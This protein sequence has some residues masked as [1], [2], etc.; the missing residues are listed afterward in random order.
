MTDKEL[1]ELW[2][3]IDGLFAYDSGF[4]DAG[5]KDERLRAWVK[6][7]IN[8]PEFGA[9]RL[10]EFAKRYL[11]PPYGLSDLKEFIDWLSEYMD[12]DV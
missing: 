10:A 4:T 9:R 1:V 12:Y 11:E 5:I 2:D 8:D 3:A 7:V 6:E